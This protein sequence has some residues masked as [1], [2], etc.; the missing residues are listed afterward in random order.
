MEV[1]YPQHTWT[2]EDADKLSSAYLNHKR[3]LK[4][5]VCDGQV[6]IEKQEGKNYLKKEYV[7][8]HFFLI[9]TCAG[10]ERRDIRTYGRGR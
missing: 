7:N 1:D 10:C 2:Q 3:D 4:C 6:A 9:F 5:P 8:T